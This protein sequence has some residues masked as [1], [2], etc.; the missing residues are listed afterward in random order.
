MSETTTVVREL[1]AWLAGRNRDYTAYPSRPL[2]LSREV[3]K[4]ARDELVY[5]EYKIAD[6]E[7]IDA[8]H[9]QMIREARAQ[10]LDDA[11]RAVSLL[12]WQAPF[13]GHDA[14][15]I[16]CIDAIRALKDKP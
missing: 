13:N 7:R 8:L 11:M 12:K 15:L 14:G 16:A 1:D 4:C 5:A 2:P 9:V 6:L 10:A 3:I